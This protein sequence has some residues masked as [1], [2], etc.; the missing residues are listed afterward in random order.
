MCPSAPRVCS[1]PGGQK[2][3][4]SLSL[5]L[6]DGWGISCE[7]TLRWMSLDVSDEKSA[8]VQVV[9]WCHEATSHHLSRCDLDLCCYMASLGHNE[10]ICFCLKQILK[11]TRTTRTPAFWGYPPMPH[12]YPYYWPVHF[13]S[14][15]HTIDQ[16]ISDPKSKQG[17]SRKIRKK[18][19]FYN[20]VINLT[21]DTSSN[22]SDYLWQIWKKSI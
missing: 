22:G 9:A 19:K 1:E 3:V 2:P 17:E 7:I 12:D 21:R 6:I 13:E 15:V 10:F 5:D 11:A 18:L 20:F 14:Q 8:L 16:F 4:L